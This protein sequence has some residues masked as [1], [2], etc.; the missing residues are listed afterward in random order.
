M[1][2][3]MLPAAE[4]HAHELPTRG[5][6]DALAQ[7]GLAHPGRT[8]QA[9]DGPTALGIELA[10]G[11]V[12]E[13]PLL[14]E[15]PAGLLQIDGFLVHLVPGQGRQPVKVGADHGV[16]GGPFRQP[17]QA[18]QFAARLF[19]HFFRHAGLFDGLGQLLEFLRARG[20][21]A[22]LALDGLELFAQH[23]FPLPLVHFLL[24]LLLDFLGQAQDGQLMGQQ[25][26]DPGETLVHVH[27]LEQLLLL[28]RRQIEEA[29]D[30]VDQLMWWL[31]SGAVT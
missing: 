4:G 6:G 12:F 14:V 2:W 27:G 15:D 18:G 19:R 16:F 23:E 3:M 28:F 8:H 17:L 30:G 11:Q 20:F 5:P 10:H 9:Q 1:A 7:R 13:D 31:P 24:G 21:L 26:G 29:G 22:Q 25:F